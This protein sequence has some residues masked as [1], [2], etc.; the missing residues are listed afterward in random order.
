M[1]IR[2]ELRKYYGAEHRAYRA[3]LIGIYGARCQACGRAVSNYLNLAHV[4]HDPR[5]RQRVALWCPTCHARHD[6][7][8]ARAVRRRTIARRVGQL[9]LAPEIE[10]AASPAWAI[11]RSAL[12]AA[13]EKMFE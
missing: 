12:D 7:P 13:Q 4:G 6:A 2:R 5:D 3:Q 8:H 9:W 11:P 10:H 1:P